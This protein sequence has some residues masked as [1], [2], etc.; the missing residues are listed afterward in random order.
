MDKRLNIV[1]KFYSN[2]TYR[3]IHNVRQAIN[4][5]LMSFWQRQQIATDCAHVDLRIFVL[6]GLWVFQ[7]EAYLLL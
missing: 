6:R 2:A 3:L 5:L 4:I 1:A 7:S